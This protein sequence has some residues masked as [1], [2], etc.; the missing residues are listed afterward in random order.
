MMMMKMRRCD[1]YI[2]FILVSDYAEKKSV[3]K[4]FDPIRP[5]DLIEI[6]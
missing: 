3:T 6:T 1:G 5:D 4:E 2:I